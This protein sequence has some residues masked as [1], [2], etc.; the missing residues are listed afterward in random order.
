MK[1]YWKTEIQLIIDICVVKL[2]VTMG[3][4]QPPNKRIAQ[5]EMYVV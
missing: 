4:I 3:F 2:T 5:A 1:A